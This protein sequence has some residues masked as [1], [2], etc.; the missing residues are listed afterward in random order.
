MLRHTLTLCKPQDL[1][2]PNLAFKESHVYKGATRML[3]QTLTPSKPQV[4]SKTKLASEKSHGCDFSDLV[5][6]CI[7]Y[8]ECKLEL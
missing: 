7:C 8:W 6:K 1:A 4:L 5:P 2:M 3:R